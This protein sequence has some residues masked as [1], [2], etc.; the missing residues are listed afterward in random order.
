MVK[1]KITKREFADMMFDI[2]ISN[3]VDEYLEKKC[4]KK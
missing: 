3:A 2:A 1:D 4:G